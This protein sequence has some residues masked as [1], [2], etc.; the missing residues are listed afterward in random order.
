[1]T[2]DELQS[3]EK[4]YEPKEDE[5]E[6]MEEEMHELEG[7]LLDEMLG[8]MMN[9]DGG[10]CSGTLERPQML[11]VCDLCMK[12]KHECRHNNLAQMQESSLHEDAFVEIHHN[13]NDPIALPGVSQTG[14]G[15]RGNLPSRKDIIKII[16]S[17][18]TRRLQSFEA[19]TGA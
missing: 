10:F 4:C 12:G 6:E 1:M 7:G 2:E 17:K 5:E 14:K 15:K 18:N 9:H 16:A 3:C 13:S 8:A 19:V 11:N